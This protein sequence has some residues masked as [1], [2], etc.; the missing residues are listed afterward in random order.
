M[1]DSRP[2]VAVVD[3]VLN[4]YCVCE[5]TSELHRVSCYIKHYTDFM[6][7]RNRHYSIDG[8]GNPQA[9]PLLAALERDAIKHIRDIVHPE[10]VCTSVTHEI[11][12]AQILRAFQN[13]YAKRHPQF[14]HDVRPSEFH[15]RFELFNS[16]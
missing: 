1:T 16:V 4:C 5:R 3:D 9:Q 15:G 2:I 10:I 12:E 14:R 13:N 8:R 11:T 7:K 6:E